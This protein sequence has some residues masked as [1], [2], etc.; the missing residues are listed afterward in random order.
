[1]LE[2]FLAEQQLDAVTVCIFLESCCHSEVFSFGTIMPVQ[3]P[4]P[5]FTDWIRLLGLK[6][7][8]RTQVYELCALSRCCI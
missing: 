6:L 5:V 4:K 8:R 7:I 2:L 3:R 1:M